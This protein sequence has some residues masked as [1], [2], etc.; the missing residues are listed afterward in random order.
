MAITR[1]RF[2]QNILGGSALLSAGLTAPSFLTS[3]ARLL[4][5]QGQRD[6]KVL[7]AVQLSGGNDGLNTVI[8][9]RDPLYARNRM[10]LRIAPANV[11]PL[12]DGVGLHPQMSGMAELY[13]QGQLAVVQ[14]VGYPNPKRSHFASMDVWHS[15]QGSPG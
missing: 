15:C 9:Y 13:E 7:V 11:L 4:A 14:G 5:A 3:T 8:P 1:R 6:Q 12:A 2:L 10:A